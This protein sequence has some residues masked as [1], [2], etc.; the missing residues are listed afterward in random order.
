MMPGMS[1]VE[2]K[3]LERKIAEAKFDL[4]DYLELQEKMASV[5]TLGKMMKMMPGMSKVEDKQLVAAEKQL[6]KS[7]LV[8]QAFTEEERANP[9][10]LMGKDSEPIRKRVAEESGQSLSEVNDILSQFLSARDTMQKFMEVQNA[11]SKLGM[12]GIGASQQMIANLQESR[13]VT[14][15]MVRRKKKQSVLSAKSKEKVAL[16]QKKG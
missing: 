6:K 4:N 13:K 15:G 5:G 10:S 16:G 7:K 2:D 12:S 1:K 3:Q 11:Q 8:I 14:K 9:E